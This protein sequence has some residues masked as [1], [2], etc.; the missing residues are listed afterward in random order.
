M[1]PSSLKLPENHR[2]FQNKNFRGYK[3]FLIFVENREI[4]KINTNKVDKF[5]KFHCNSFSS[6]EKFSWRGGGGG[7]ILP[8][9]HA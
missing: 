6:Q 9:P 3:F 1:L 7:G 8:T 2:T 5:T 4:R